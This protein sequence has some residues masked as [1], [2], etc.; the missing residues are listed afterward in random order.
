MP[1][2][3]VATSYFEMLQEGE[4]LTRAK[5]SMWI[6][7]EKSSCNFLAQG[8]LYREWNWNVEQKHSCHVVW[9]HQPSPDFFVVMLFILQKVVSVSYYSG[10]SGKKKRCHSSGSSPQFQGPISDKKEGIKMW[11]M[12]NFY[13]LTLA[14]KM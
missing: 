8:N 12:T 13:L 5:T 1:L 9:H 6:N 3:K 11:G 14:K 4:G 7:D 10:D 2:F